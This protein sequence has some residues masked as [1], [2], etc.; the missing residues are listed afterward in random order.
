M[1]ITKFS[2]G[3]YSLE[4]IVFYIIIW[5]LLWPC[6]FGSAGTIYY[7]HLQVRT[8]VQ[9]GWDSPKVKTL[10]PK[11]QFSN[12]RPVLFTYYHTILP[13]GSTFHLRLRK[14]SLSNNKGHRGIKET[15]SQIKDLPFPQKGKQGL[16]DFVSRTFW[17]WLLLIEEAIPQIHSNKCLPWGKEGRK[18]IGREGWSEGG[19]FWEIQV[20]HG[21]HSFSKSSLTVHYVII[22]PE[23]VISIPDLKIETLV[24]STSSLSYHLCAFL[25]I[26][27]PRQQI[28]KSTSTIERI[29][30]DNIS[31]VLSI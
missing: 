18:E 25:S 21:I 6:G 31:K 28:I 14:E 3:I 11:F 12:P 10:G 19:R 1:G 24:F 4:R 16:E 8:G 27:F 23:M 5:F 17:R 7:H 20:T 22:D 30:W 15:A 13:P 2:V 26:N 9:R 29:G